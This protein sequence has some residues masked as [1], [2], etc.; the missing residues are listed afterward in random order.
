M[1]WCH[2]KREI[3]LLKQGRIHDDNGTRTGEEMEEV[4]SLGSGGTKTMAAE[5]GV[6]VNN[7]KVD[8]MDCIPGYGVM[9]TPDSVPDRKKVV[10]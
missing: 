1:L 9:S 7:E 2:A 10:S 5:N 8:D 4:K 3:L 6:A